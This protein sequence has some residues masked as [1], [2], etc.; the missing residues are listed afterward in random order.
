[1]LFAYHSSWCLSGQKYV[2]PQFESRASYTHPDHVNSYLT[3]S[4]FNWGEERRGC[5]GYLSSDYNQ[6]ENNIQVFG[7]IF[8]KGWKLSK[9]N[10]KRRNNHFPELFFKRNGLIRR[11]GAGNCRYLTL[12]FRKE[13]QQMLRFSEHMYQ[14]WHFFQ[15]IYCDSKHLCFPY[16]DTNTFSKVHQYQISKLK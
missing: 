2:H 16:V 15:Y 11:S 13:M 4:V 14:N 12:Y 1:M 6:E 3:P 7:C 5:S 10:F 8:L 9:I